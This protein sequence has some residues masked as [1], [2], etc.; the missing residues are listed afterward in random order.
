MM[1]CC[2]ITLTSPYNQITLRQYS[3]IDS[4]H[5]FILVQSFPSSTQTFYSACFTI[6]IFRIFKMSHQHF[7]RRVFSPPALLAANSISLHYN[8]DSSFV[9]ENCEFEFIS[10]TWIFNCL[11]YFSPVSLDR[12]CRTCSGKAITKF[13]CSLLSNGCLVDSPTYVAPFL[14]CTL[15]LGV[16]FVWKGRGERRTSAAVTARA[17][18]SALNSGRKGMATRDGV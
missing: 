16:A 8:I 14:V 3:T 10:V 7:F 15:L 6:R 2:L 1:A 9:R 12:T 18:I 5:A 11:F 17:K 4:N 13:S